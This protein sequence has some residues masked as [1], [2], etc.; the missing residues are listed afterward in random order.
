[1]GFLDSGFICEFT[2]IESRPFDVMPFDSPHGKSPHRVAVVSLTCIFTPIILARPLYLMCS[3]LVFNL[4]SH[5]ALPG[6]LE[7]HYST[8]LVPL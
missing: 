2:V 1:M 5:F 3:L 8:L 6:S 4:V 7:T